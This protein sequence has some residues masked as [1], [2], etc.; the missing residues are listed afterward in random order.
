MS[1]PGQFVELDRRAFLKTLG[2]AGATTI[3]VAASAPLTRAQSVGAQVDQIETFETEG[4]TDNTWELHVDAGNKFDPNYHHHHF[5]PREW[6]RKSLRIKIGPDNGGCFG[7]RTDLQ[8]N[9]NGYLFTGSLYVAEDNLADNTSITAF[10]SK[11]FDW[12]GSL[13]CWRLY[14]LRQN[15]Q[16]WLALVLGLNTDTMNPSGRI[17]LCNIEAHR[18]YDMMI[19]Y[20]TKRRVYAWTVSGVLMAYGDMPSDY[21][22]VGARIIGSSSSG[23]GRNTTILIDNVRWQECK[24]F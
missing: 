19:L 23:L 9:L 4:G 18:A 15:G 22:L 24:N 3:F 14:V 1:V 12:T 7:V 20:D 11:P 8:P 13:A 17:G 10:I 5:L 21:P 16:L 2:A 6:G